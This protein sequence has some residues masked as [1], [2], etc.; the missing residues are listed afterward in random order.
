MGGGWQVRIEEKNY[1]TKKLGVHF[2]ISLFFFCFKIN[3]LKYELK[4]IKKYKNKSRKKSKNKL[5]EG[6]I[7]QK[8]FIH[9]SMWKQ[10]H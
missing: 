4:K 8:M 7:I 1:T 5:R 9:F 6:K 3:F 2:I 10:F